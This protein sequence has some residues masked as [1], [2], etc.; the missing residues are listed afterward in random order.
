M[1]RRLYSVILFFVIILF[2]PQLSAQYSIKGKITTENGNPLPDAIIS[3]N[4]NTT[5]SNQQG[6]YQ[7][8]LL[9]EGNI[10]LS[11]SYTGFTTIDTVITLNK[12]LTIDFILKPYVNNLSEVVIKRKVLQ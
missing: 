1:F 11:V 4:Q 5:F 9:E 2:S 6:Y 12:P 7:T 3:Y 8:H 10:Y